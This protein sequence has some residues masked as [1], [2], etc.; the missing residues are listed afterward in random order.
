MDNKDNILNKLIKD[1]KTWILLV[2]IIVFITGII[3]VNKNNNETKYFVNENGVKEEIKKYLVKI[4]IDFPGNLIF[5]TYDVMLKND[6]QDILINHGKNK[7]IE[8]SLKEGNNKLIFVNNEDSNIKNEITLEVHSNIEIGYRI[9]CHYNRIDIEELY[10]DRD[11]KISEDEIKIAFSKSE[12]TIKDKDIVINK[13]KE[14]GFTNIKENPVYDITFGLFASEKQ[15]SSVT[16]DGKE[17]YKRGDVFK[18]DAEIIVS[19]HMKQ[20]DDPERVKAPYDSNTAQNV[21]YQTVIDDFK[22]NGFTNITSKTTTTTDKNQNNKV[23][24]IYIDL[25]KAD[26]QKSYEKDDKVEITYYVY[27][28]PKENTSQNTKPKDE[29]AS[30]KSNM[31]AQKEFKDVAKRLYPYGVDLD[32]FNT[33]NINEYKGNGIWYFKVKATITNK[34]GAK[35]NCYLSANVDL[36]TDMVKNMKELKK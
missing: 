25:F 23:K 19:Y 2:T 18:K 7:D 22:K 33:L 8:L 31:W 17:D 30:G 26:R 10:L 21:D 34:Y 36:K 27:T 24:E 32:W 4:H 28:E 15:T 11:E 3:I 5:S 1:S 29:Y 35:R 13:L 6:D 20:D 14:Y 9:S 12:F 16:I